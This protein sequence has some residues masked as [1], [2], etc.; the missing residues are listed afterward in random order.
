MARIKPAGFRALDT[1]ERYR[2]E[3]EVGEALSNPET[4]KTRG[5]RTEMSL[6]RQESQQNP[7]PHPGTLISPPF[8]K[9]L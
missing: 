4:C 3:K 8:P 9:T 7:Q 1:A 5:T 2:T 6:H